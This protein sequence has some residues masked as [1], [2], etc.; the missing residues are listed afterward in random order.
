MVRAAFVMLAACGRIGFDPV[1]GAAGDGAGGDGSARIDVGSAVPVALAQAPICVDNVG[2]TSITIPFA[3]VTAGDL[4]I[5]AYADEDSGTVASIKDNTIT[6]WSRVDASASAAGAV[7]YR[8]LVANV[9]SVVL[10]LNDVPGAACFYEVSGLDATAP[11]DTA[12]IND[13]GTVAGGT[14]TGPAVTTATANEFI[15]ASANV[16]DGVTG[17]HAGNNFTNDSLLHTDGHAHLITAGI[18]TYTPVWDDPLGTFSAY[19]AA[20]KGP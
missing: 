17:M 6:S 11:V 7:Y 3:V 9:T 19:T 14:A 8:V 10:T 1:V 18:G 16:S 5:V 2:Q 15:V 4:G 20:F 12:A 13:S